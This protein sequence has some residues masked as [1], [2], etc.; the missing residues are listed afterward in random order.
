M[1]ISETFARNFELYD[2]SM[3][4]TLQAAVM[5]SPLAGTLAG[6][7][8]HGTGAA[9]LTGLWAG[10][11]VA[12]AML[13]VYAFPVSRIVEEAKKIPSLTK[14][15][16]KD[17]FR[18]S[19][20]ASKLVNG[21]KEGYQSLLAVLPTGLAATGAAAGVTVMAPGVALPWALTGLPILGP[22]ALAAAVG[23]GAAGFILGGKLGT[24][25]ADKLDK[26]FVRPLP[27]GEEQTFGQKMKSFLGR[28]I[29]YRQKGQPAIASRHPASAGAMVASAIAGT[30]VAVVFNLATW[31]LGLAGA[32]VAGALTLPMQRASVERELRELEKAG[33]TED[34]GM[35]G[36]VGLSPSN[37]PVPLNGLNLKENFDK[38]RQPQPVQEPQPEPA[39][40]AS[41]AAKKN[42]PRWMR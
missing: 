39:I 29:P 32:F 11:V 27:S 33:V 35:A 3:R 38:S 18:P 19:N 8:V 7:G 24:V 34:P 5:V 1:K 2:N 6:L 17:F 20:L 16:I 40:G 28:I 23:L 12:L 25:I 4:Q 41:N 10:P 30:V 36:R 21:L 15:D 42:L 9:M 37:T 31:P 22:W 13:G 26:N 14:Q